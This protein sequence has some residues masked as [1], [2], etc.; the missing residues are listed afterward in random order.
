MTALKTRRTLFDPAQLDDPQWSQAPQAQ[1]KTFA[2]PQGM[3]VSE[4]LLTTYRDG[5]WG[6]IA[7][8]GVRGWQTRHSLTLLLEFESS[9][10]HRAFIGPDHFLDRVA[11][12]FPTDQNTLFMT[13][14]S[15][16]SPGFIWSWRADG[17]TE[18]LLAQG[19]GT[20]TSLSNEGLRSQSHHD[21][22]RWRIQLSGPQI[23][24]T[25]RRFAIAA[26]SGANKERAGLKAFSQE[27]IELDAL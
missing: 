25:P 8:V 1:I 19:P 12:F 11:V 18:K 22:K 27:W 14:G 26:W 5:E 9:Q 23:V 20:L 13:M 2:T 15:P 16:Q 10:Q 17:K 6:R 24:N 21:G 4:Y 7:T 3:Q